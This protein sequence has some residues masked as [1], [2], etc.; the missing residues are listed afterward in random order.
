MCCTAPAT[1]TRPT[2]P[3]SPPRPA[4]G[5][6]QKGPSQEW[7]RAPNLDCAKVCTCLHRVKMVYYKRPSVVNKNIQKHQ[8]TSLCARFA[9]KL[10]LA[11]TKSSKRHKFPEQ[12]PSSH[13]T[14]H[15]FFLRT[16][17]GHAKTSFNLQRRLQAHVCSLLRLFFAIRVPLD[18]TRTAPA[19]R[20]GALGLCQQGARG[21]PEARL[22]SLA[23]QQGE[24]GSTRAR[25]LF[26]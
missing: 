20:A 23:I 19:Q 21:V 4:P 25:L 22:L 6:A 13:K 24:R 26:N 9:T 10:T 5:Q 16:Q 11:V 14:T 2:G 7:S 3:S 8:L 18:L 12:S 17:L 15:H 1:R